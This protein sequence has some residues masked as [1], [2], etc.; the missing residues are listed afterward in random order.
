MAD[1]DDTL[2][3]DEYTVDHSDNDINF[4]QPDD[5]QEDNLAIEDLGVDQQLDVQSVRRVVPKLDADR[6]L[7]PAFG[8]PVLLKRLRA[9]RYRGKGH[10]KSYL[11]KYM[12]HYQL[13]ANRIWAKANVRDFILIERSAGNDPRIKEYRTELIRED[14]VRLERHKSKHEQKT[15]RES[16]AN[17]ET[18]VDLD[19]VSTTAT[20]DTSATPKTGNY[21]SASIFDVTRPLD[22]SS[23]ETPQKSGSGSPE[24]GAE[25]N[26]SKD[27]SAVDGAD[28]DGSDNARSPANSEGPGKADGSNKQATDD[29]EDATMFEQEEVVFDDE[30]D[31]AMYE[32]LGL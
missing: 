29:Y 31:A 14:M 8:Y 4:N 7:N 21:R 26:N 22:E 32:D 16:R 15:R 11:K 10:E 13:W 23:K 1:Y 9:T 24:E 30:E 5:I 20:Q 6:L 17:E 19:T 27:D 2:D 12:M 28:I 3:L 25:E 18:N